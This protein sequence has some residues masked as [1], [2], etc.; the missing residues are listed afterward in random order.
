MK[1]NCLGNWTATES[2]FIIKPGALLLKPLIL[3]L[4]EQRFQNALRLLR[5][6][7]V[8]DYVMVLVF[9]VTNFVWCETVNH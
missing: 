1:G 4:F 3:S 7:W 2:V 5:F 9:E 8:L 6:V